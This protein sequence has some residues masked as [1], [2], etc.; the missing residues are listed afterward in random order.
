MDMTNLQYPIGR[1]AK[2]T[3]PLVDTER[4]RLIDQIAQVPTTVRALVTNLSD[5]ELETPYRP[6]GWTIR[7]VVHHLPDSHVNAYI[8][9]KLAVTEDRPPIKPYAEEKWAELPD[10]QSAPVEMSLDLL[11]AIHRRWVVFLRDLPRSQFAREYLHPDMGPVDLDTA[12]ALYAWHGN[13]H[14]AHIGQAVSTSR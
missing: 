14:I 6:G 4:R 1:F 12:V 9:F 10:G 3:V 8:R 2:P 5:R 13:H 11:A 7:Q